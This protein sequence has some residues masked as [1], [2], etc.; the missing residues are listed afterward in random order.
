[1]EHE[2]GDVEEGVGGGQG[3]ERAGSQQGVGGVAEEGDGADSERRQ[4][5]LSQWCIETADEGIE[6]RIVYHGVS[7][8][9]WDTVMYVVVY[10]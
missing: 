8:G 10:F 4:S 5:G 7:M 6:E 9:A 2:S 1:M 3:V